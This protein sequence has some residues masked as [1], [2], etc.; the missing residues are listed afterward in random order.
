MKTLITGERG[1][2]GA[3]IF[4]FYQD[5]GLVIQAFD[6]SIDARADRI[7]HLAAKSPPAT[8]D[9]ICRSNILYLKKIV[10]YAEKNCINEVVFF[11]G[12]SVYGEQN[13]EDVEEDDCIRAPDLY[14]VSKL[15]GEEFLRKSHLKVLC[16]RLPG[17]L[18]YRNDTNFL[19][20]CYIKLNKN[21]CVELT[22]SEKLF[23]NF[24][25]IRNIFEFLVIIITFS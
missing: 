20:R 2:I 7:L 19:S 25:S 11:S 16:L 10:D 23:N 14:G 22:N 13:K 6:E 12:M 24:I 15:F 8:G 5:S 17:I 1:D 4:K 9:E 21:E 3:A 18:G